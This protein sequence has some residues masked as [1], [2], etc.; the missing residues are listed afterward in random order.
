MEFVFREGDIVSGGA[1]VRNVE[2]MQLG[3]RIHRKIQKS[4]G[5]GYESEVPLFTIQ[6]FKSAEYEEDFS[7]KIEGRAD[8]IFTDGDL[9]VIDEIKGVYLPVQDL[10]KPLF[11]HQ[12]QAMCYAYIV[13]ENENLDE[14][15][16]Q[17]TYCHM[18]TEQ[19][20]RFRETFSRIEIVQWFRNL[21]DEY[22][23]WAVYQYDWKKQR[24]ASITELTFPFSYRPGQKELAA[25]TITRTVAEDCF[26]LL[27]KQKLLFKTLTITAKEKM[28]VMETVSCNP[29]ECE[30]AKGHY[31]RVN[32]AVYDMLIHEHKMSR[33]MIEK[34]A[35]KHQVCP[36]EMALDAAL[37]A[38]AVICDYNYVFDPNVYLRRFFSTEKKGNMVLLVDEAHNLVERGREMYSARLVKED[39]LAVKKIVKAMERHEKRPEVHYILRK[40]EKSL[41]AANRVLLAWKKECD[42]FEVISDAG[43]LEF[44]LL[45]VAGDY[46]LV[47]KEYPVLPERDTILSLY[48]DVRR[49]LAVLEKFDE[50]DRIYLDYDEERKFR[51][52][53]QCMDPSGCLKE[54]MER[55]QS[56]IFFS[57]TLLPIRYYKEQL[58]GEKEDAAVYAKSVFLPEQRKVMIARDV[59]TKYTRRGATE[60]EKIAAYIDS[61][62]SAKEG[63]YLLFFPSYRFMD[64]I[65]TRL[66][67]RENQ[68]I[69]VQMP[70]MREREREEFLEAFSE[71]T[72]KSVIGC[73]V[74]G[75]IFS[76]GIDLKEECLIGAVVVGTGIP[77][78]CHERELFKDYYEE[79]KGDGF[80]YAYL[81]PAVNKVFQAGGRVIRTINDKGAILLLDER[82]MQKQYQD[83]FPREWYPFDVVNCEKMRE[84][85]ADFW[86]E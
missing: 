34:Y 45:R 72:G 28:C 21:M 61:F 44:A 68:K 30:R 4:M 41:E 26:E 81:Y 70:E 65:V 24:N 55:V 58:G 11:I 15:G 37:F 59:T 16:V 19:V 84:L 22:E 13:A 63:N 80:S 36:F 7:L 49:F 10:E 23:K 38:D 17:L 86:Q 50:S 77:M 82:F 54:V 69:L 9:T 1:G 8:G 62:I 3:S 47:A 6:K 18:E 67:N 5:V 27:G 60:Y 29:G 75:G 46:E 79:K 73:C 33:D 64:E 48:F 40:F 74:M 14:I 31:N 52:K 12:A 2:A 76:E 66:P 71:E 83:L 42:E 57:A 39:F 78:V 20:V 35:E 53:I 56:T 25:K 32:E 51:I 85:L 43:M